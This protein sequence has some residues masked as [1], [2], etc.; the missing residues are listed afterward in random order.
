MFVGDFVYMCGGVLCCLLVWWVIVVLV[1]F[2]FVCRLGVVWV[3]TYGL[4][5]VGYWL[6]VALGSCLGLIAAGWLV[7]VWCW[8]VVEV[9]LLWC[10]YVVCFAS[11]CGLCYS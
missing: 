4:I 9:I 10:C 3:V 2:R 6:F 5:L 7:C 11:W 1:V 8:L